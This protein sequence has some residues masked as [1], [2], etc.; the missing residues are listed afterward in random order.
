MLVLSH[1]LIL[2][3]PGQ[4]NNSYIFPGVGLG[5]VASGST[6]VTDLDMLI[7]AK[8]LATCLTDERLQTGCL[9]PPLEEIRAVSAIV[10][11]AVAEAA[12]NNGTA[13][14]PRPDDIIAFCKSKMYVP[15]Y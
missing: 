14:V 13:T 10:A 1:D 7:A 12:W 4:G 5:V 15:K 8:A 9:Y 2:F 3:F 11:A 6:R